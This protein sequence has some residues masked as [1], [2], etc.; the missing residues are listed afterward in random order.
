MYH[1]R[2]INAGEVLRSG[3]DFCTTTAPINRRAFPDSRYLAE[4]RCRGIVGGEKV[5]ASSALLFDGQRRIIEPSRC[6]F[7]AALHI[8]SVVIPASANPANFFKFPVACK[9]E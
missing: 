9:A 3:L 2:S 7:K 8:L 1:G 4:G 5:R 6:S